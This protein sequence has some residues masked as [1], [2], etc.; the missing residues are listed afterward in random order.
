MELHRI[1]A[2]LGYKLWIHCDPDQGILKYELY[3]I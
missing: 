1:Q 2:I 3:L